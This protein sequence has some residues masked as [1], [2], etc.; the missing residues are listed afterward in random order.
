MRRGVGSQ[1]MTSDGGG[2]G[3][4][5]VPPTNYDIIYEQPIAQVL[6]CL[7]LNVATLSKEYG[8][9]FIWELC[10]FEVIELLSHNPVKRCKTWLLTAHGNLL[11]T[12]HL[13]LPSSKSFIVSSSYII[14][15]S[16]YFIIL[17]ISSPSNS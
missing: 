12:L 4:I 17:F 15:S 2:D 5:M 10:I 3:G 14:I 8:G 13:T 9:N 16:F 7:G 11:Q 6:L 1:K